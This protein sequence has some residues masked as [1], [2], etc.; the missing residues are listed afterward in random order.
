MIG[1]AL[2][3]KLNRAHALLLAA[4]TGHPGEAIALAE[5]ALRLAEGSAAKDAHAAELVL[6]ARGMIGLVLENRLRETEAND[7][8][9]IGWVAAAGDTAD[10][11]MALALAWQRRDPQR[12]RALLIWFFDFGARVYRRHQPH[13]LAEFLEEGDPANQLPGATAHLPELRA[14]ATHALASAR[15]DQETPRLLLAGSEPTNRLLQTRRDL[16]AAQRRRVQT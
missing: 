1:A 8:R 14:I 12:F 13:F 2:P 15:R 7:R 16:A 4:A 10:S 9:R 5:A 6:R 11:G 3:P